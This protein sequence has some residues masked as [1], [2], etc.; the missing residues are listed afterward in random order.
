M[1]GGAVVLNEEERATLDAMARDTRLLDGLTIHPH[2]GDGPLPEE[3]EPLP[4]NGQKTALAA[5]G[6]CAVGVMVFSWMALAPADDPEWPRQGMDGFKRGLLMFGLG[7]GVLVGAGLAVMW[8][9]LGEVITKFFVLGVHVISAVVIFWAS[10]TQFTRVNVAVRPLAVL[11]V[12]LAVVVVVLAV[13]WNRRNTAEEAE[14]TRALRVRHPWPRTPLLPV[15]D[16]VRREWG[17]PGQDYGA[18]EKYGADNVNRGRAGEKAV[19]QMLSEIAA[20][21]PY[22]RVF[23]QVRFPNS[24]NADI[25]HVIVRGDRSILVDAKNWKPGHYSWVGDGQTLERDGQ[26]FVGGLTHMPE[27]TRTLTD[28]MGA[29]GV[30]PVC[31]IVLANPMGG[32]ESTVDNTRAPAAVA[33]ASMSVARAWIEEYLGLSGHLD[34][35]QA[36]RAARLDRYVLRF[37]LGMLK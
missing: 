36:E 19:A 20:K 26:L 6:L 25:D 10:S 9:L 35:E 4:R 16:L 21:D 23:N 2:T 13:R 8:T 14:R 17:T 34:A 1:P 3:L 22:V 28:W 29:M 27:A 30:S 11:S 7:A 12:V 33:L 15:E 32:A 37:W 24:N 18:V 5:L 31:Y